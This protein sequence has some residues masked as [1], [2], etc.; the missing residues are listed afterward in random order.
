MKLISM[1]DFVLEE[2]KGGQR[3]NSITT[4]LHQE[5]RN[6][7][8]YAK[9]L[10]QE[11]KLEMLIPCDENGEI[12]ERPVFQDDFSE[13]QLCNFQILREEFEEAESKVLFYNVDYFYDE[14]RL[15][16][17]FGEIFTH[18]EDL[19][20]GYTIEDLAC[21]YNLDLRTNIIERI[22]S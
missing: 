16:I 6:I 17:K 8:K 11:I 18:F 19:K 22:F 10:K 15:T 9:F 2:Q 3:V 12:L 21:W 20:N 13:D 14:G 1:I 5:L 4:Q 7:K